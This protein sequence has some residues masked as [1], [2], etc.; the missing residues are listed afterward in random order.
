MVMSA[1]VFYYL[2]RDYENNALLFPRM[3]VILMLCLAGI[4]AVAELFKMKKPDL[5]AD[6][7]ST[8]TFP[9]LR[10]LFVLAAIVGYIWVLEDLGFYTTGFLFFFVVTLVIQGFRRTPK[11]IAVRFA[12]CFGF[13]AFLYLLFSVL[14][15]VQLPKGILV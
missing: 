8:E 13:M 12:Y 5:D 2:M 14:L 7:P 11:V 1:M 10:V 3:M 9:L 6:C 4:K 15:K